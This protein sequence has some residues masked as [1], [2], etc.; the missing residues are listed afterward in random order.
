MYPMKRRTVLTTGAVSGVGFLAGCSD[1]D[2]KASDGTRTPVPDDETRHE[3]GAR[4]EMNDGGEPGQEGFWLPQD[5]LIPGAVEEGW[6]LFETATD[7]TAEDVETR[8]QRNDLR[9]TWE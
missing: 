9:A 7:M 8:L 4:L 1:G 6:V 5:D 3:E 2:E